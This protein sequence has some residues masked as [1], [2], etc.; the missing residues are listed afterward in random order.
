LN[1]ITIF[2]PTRNRLES[3]KKTLDGINK[4]VPTSHV[5]IGNCSS[6]KYLKEVGDLIKLYN[7]AKEIIY[8]PDPGASISYNNLFMD[9]VEDDLAIW[10]ADDVEFIREID[11]LVSLFDDEKIN[12]V[13]LPMIDDLTSDSNLGEGWPKDKFDCAIWINSFGCRVAHHAIIRTNFFKKHGVADRDYPIDNFCD[14]RIG[15]KDRIWPEDGAYLYHKRVFDETRINS[16]YF[17]DRF[18]LP[19]E[20]IYRKDLNIDKASDRDK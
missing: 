15:K 17:E 18:V 9:N 14:I 4:F 11:N 10:L 19:K 13:G 7:N 5:I 2:L 1:N 12:L 6:S 20:H 3:L 8:N 16:I